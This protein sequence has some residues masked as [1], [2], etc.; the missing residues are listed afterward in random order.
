M[1]TRREVVRRR[2]IIT[3]ALLVVLV[4]IPAVLW[5]IDT[6]YMPMDMLLAAVMRKLGLTAFLDQVRQ[7]G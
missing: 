2:V 1:R 7:G 5:A 4:G 3:V 6:Y